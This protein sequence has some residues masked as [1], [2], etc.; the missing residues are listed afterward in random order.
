[1][2]S[3][4]QG[5]LLIFSTFITSDENLKFNRWIQ[6]FKFFLFPQTNYEIYELFS[7]RK[8]N[9]YFVNEFCSKFPLQNFKVVE[10]LRI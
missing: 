6:A 8:I 7:G 5:L 4:K 2:T 1:M 3:N 10:T 9:F